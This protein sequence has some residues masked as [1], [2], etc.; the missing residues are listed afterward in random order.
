MRI[1]YDDDV[2][3]HDVAILLNPVAGGGRAIRALNQVLPVLNAAGV[4]VDVWTSDAA[5]DLERHAREAAA[6]RSERVIAIGGDGSVQEVANGLLSAPDPPSMAVIPAGRGNDLARTLG[7]PM[8]VADA[9]RLAIKGDPRAMD[10]GECN[11]RYFVIAGGIGFDGEVAYRVSHAARPWQRAKAVYLAGTLLELRR[12]RN[13]ELKIEMDGKTIERRVLL[14]AITNCPYYGGGMMICP[15]ADIADGLLDVCIVGDISRREALREIPGIYRGRH[16]SNPAVEFH[17]ARTV[18]VEGGADVR[19]HLDGEPSGP[20]PLTFRVL[21]AAL[22][23]V[24]PV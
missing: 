1:C 12:Y 23:V 5:G 21:P 19:S 8:R 4:A 24:A 2:R 15:E 22:R 13:R 20:P 18:R 10:V 9:A 11:G 6:R 17:R 7:I 3:A 16:V 14:V